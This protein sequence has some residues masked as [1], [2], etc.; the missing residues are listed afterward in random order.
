MYNF[1]NIF[2]NLIMSQLTLRGF[3]CHSFVLISAFFG[4]FDMFFVLS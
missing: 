1:V 4:T 3:Y 2:I